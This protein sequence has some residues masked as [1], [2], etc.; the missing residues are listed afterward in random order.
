MKHSA[1]EDVL[2]WSNFLPQNYIAHLSNSGTV[3]QMCY[4]FLKSYLGIICCQ[5]NILVLFLRQR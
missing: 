2:L 3:W 4:I 1:S 5:I